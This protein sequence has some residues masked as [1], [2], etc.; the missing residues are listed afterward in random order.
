MRE[1]KGYSLKRSRGLVPHFYDANSQS[2]R[3]G[4]DKNW[5]REAHRNHSVM[6]RMAFAETPSANGYIRGH[7]FPENRP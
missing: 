1:R 6:Q 3:A 5:P 2:Y 7:C 4:A